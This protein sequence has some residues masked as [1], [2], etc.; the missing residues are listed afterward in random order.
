MFVCAHDKAA[1]AIKSLVTA[2][3]PIVFIA[4]RAIRTSESVKTYRWIASCY[5][6]WKESMKGMINLEH[7][8]M[9][10]ATR[11]LILGGIF[12]VNITAVVTISNVIISVVTKE[13]VT[14]ILG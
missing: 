1:G 13:S 8:N 4:T 9:I 10:F 3:V 11:P 5:S 2:T 14:T 12:A 7:T 6:K